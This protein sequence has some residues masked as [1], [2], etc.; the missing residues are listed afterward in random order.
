[1]A[2]Q[3]LDTQAGTPNKFHGETMGVAQRIQGSCRDSPFFDALE[4]L[5]ERKFPGN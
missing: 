5:C 3:G 4:P 1:M 2:I